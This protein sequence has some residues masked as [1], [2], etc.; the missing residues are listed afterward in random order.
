MWK[1][2]R[3]YTTTL[4]WIA[5][6]HYSV[7]SADPPCVA[8]VAA[9][10]TEYTIQGDRS[11]YTGFIWVRPYDSR[12]V[13]VCN[14]SCSPVAGYS[15]TVNGTHSTL[16]IH[17]VGTIDAG[18]WKIVDAL[19]V[20]AV[21]V[22]VCQLRVAKLPRCN[23]SSDA[24]PTALQ[25]NTNL[26]LTVDIREF[27]CSQEAGFY[28]TT[29]NVTEMLMK[30][31]VTDVSDVITSSTFSVTPARLGDVTV[32][33]TCD[34]SSWD[35]NCDGMRSLGVGSADSPCAGGV[36]LLYTQYTIQTDRSSFTGIA[37][38]RPTDGRYVV[39]CNP[40]C[41]PVPGYSADTNA[42]HR[43]LTI[44]SVG[45]V[46]AGVWKVLD[47]AVV[48]AVPV[49]ACRLTVE[50]LPRCN[51]SSDADPTALQPN[52]S[53]TLTVDIREF[54]CS[55][56]AGFY[57]TTGNV[58]EMLM[59]HNVTDVNDVIT[60][61]TFSVTPARLGDVT[62]SYTCDVNSWDVN[63]DGVRSLGVRSADSPCVGGVALLGTQSTIEGDRSSFTGFVWERPTDGRYVVTCNPSCSPGPGYSAEI[64]ATHSTLTIHSV[65][66]VDAGV[67]KVL[68]VAVFGAVSI[69]VCQLTV[70]KLPR[71][72]VSS[73]ADPTALQP[74]TNLTLT[75][76]IREYYCSQEAG[77]YLTTG[78]VTEM[79][80]KHNVTDVNDV[81]SSSTFSVTPA[82]LGDVTVSYTCD[83]TRWDLNC[84]G[85]R[86]L[87]MELPQCNVSSDA[88]PT[89]LKPNTNLTLTV[90]IRE[91]FCS[92]GA[93]FYLTTGNVTEMLMKYNVT[94]V[95]DVI[96]SSTFSVTPARL[97]DVTVSYM[98]DVSRWNLNCDGVR[99]L[100]LELPQ[101]NVSSDADPT[102][103]KPNTNLTLTVD[104]RES[105]C[106]QGAGFYLTTGNVTEMLMK[107][108]VTDVSD[109]I[110][111]STFSVTPARLGD[112]T[113][114][115]T[116]DISR[117]NLNCDGVR[118]LSLE[119]PQ[120]N[121]SSDADPTALQPNTNL[122]LTVDIRESFCS[123]GAGF[124]LTTG[125]VT[126]MLMKHN[127]TDV[128]DVITSSTFSVTPSR[129]GD[130][131]VSYTCDVNRWN[132]NCDGVSNLS[133]DQVVLV[134]PTC[135]YCTSHT[136]SSLNIQWVY[137]GNT[138]YSLTYVINYRLNDKDGI[139]DR[140]I[141]IPT[142]KSET[143]YTTTLTELQE[144]NL[145][146]F[147]LVVDGGYLGQSEAVS[148]TCFT[149]HSEGSESSV[150]SMGVGVVMGIGV[151]LVALAVCLGVEFAF[152][153]KLAA[154]YSGTDSAENDRQIKVQV[155]QSSQGRDSSVYSQTEECTYEVPSPQNLYELQLPYNPYDDLKPQPVSVTYEEVKNVSY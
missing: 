10:R 124:Y 115:Y 35:V 145:Y 1:P 39:T 59:K 82:R 25:P 88:D 122:T 136:E 104:I 143:I 153:R 20:G 16:T 117:W 112:V 69:P 120:C 110:T 135:F 111:S 81:I 79:L 132:L 53:L 133:L 106:S 90:D 4:A 84:D 58:T 74:N 134:K 26:T 129:L 119:L 43:T 76:D 89:A 109:V 126:E 140:T 121:V 102:A 148:T 97:G 15:A 28:L 22:D 127:V 30:Y 38:V 131:T 86:S 85:L 125:N 107:H 7:D 31:N 40:S 45:V 63:C 78:N 27:Y 118:N 12:Y 17:S 9:L 68:D 2:G 116:C 42:T 44:H 123:Q 6:I 141:T 146:Y 14:P 23:V 41:S 72:N 73:D 138:L 18:T 71:C 100:S 11:N 50:K 60:S 137:P 128:S 103:L 62:V 29:G 46:D 52:T 21:P 5:C 149:R 19:V 150:S 91:S 47:A 108:N 101:C 33:Y 54:Y 24:D 151:M 57:L 87:V 96:T 49:P 77:F 95:S 55:Q 51:V 3:L 105:F 93:G 139:D 113:V 147:R 94:D 142:D 98:C 8:G 48:G 70:E 13:V 37:W 56:E 65:G 36:A 80:M 83:V 34:V 155:S 66:M 67:W 154:I 130:V 152:R 64:N 61:S 99:N 32:S 92:Q 75:V 144:D 114:S